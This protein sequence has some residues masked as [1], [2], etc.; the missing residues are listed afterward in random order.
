MKITMLLKLAAMMVLVCKMAIFFSWKSL[1]QDR[2]EHLEVQE[3][4]EVLE[5]AAPRVLLVPTLQF[6]F[7]GIQLNPPPR[8][9]K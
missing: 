7:S 8:M 1:R 2:P 3:L 6:A 5:P 9:D 4:Q